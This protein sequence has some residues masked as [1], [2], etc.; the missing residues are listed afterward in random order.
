MA[1]DEIARRTTF[2][3]RALLFRNIPDP[4]GRKNTGDAR[5]FEYIPP[6]KGTG[7]ADVNTN[8]TATPL[9]SQVLC[10]AHESIVPG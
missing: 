10:P 6:V 2:A 8:T 7:L 1:N 5:K 9:T 3:E 4:T